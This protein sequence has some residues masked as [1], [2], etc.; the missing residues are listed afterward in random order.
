VCVC[1]CVCVPRACACV[2]VHA[3]V[4]ACA[5]LKLPH[6]RAQK[7]QQQ[8]DGLAT[9]V[10]KDVFLAIVYSA[11]ENQAQPSDLEKSFSLF[12]KDGDGT[13]DMSEFEEGLLALGDMNPLDREDQV[14]FL[15]KIDTDGDSTLSAK[16]LLHWLHSDTFENFAAAADAPRKESHAKATSR[17]HHQ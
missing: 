1:G 3:C 4:R 2:C 15:K 14:A 12:D 6:P 11:L 10:E 17:G 9:R 5:L 16:E 13:I 7:Q 8:Q